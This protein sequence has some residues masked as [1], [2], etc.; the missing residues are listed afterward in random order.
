VKVVSNIPTATRRFRVHLLPQT[1]TGWWSGRLFLAA[2][3]LFIATI[4]VVNVAGQRG[5][6]IAFTMIPAGIAAVLGGITAAVAVLRFRERGAL[7]F[8][9]LLVGLAVVWFLIGEVTTPH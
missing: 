6:W 9:S 2:I 1:A 3:T 5:L 7:A 8:I 4:L